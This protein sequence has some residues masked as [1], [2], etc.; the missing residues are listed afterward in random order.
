MKPHSNTFSSQQNQQN[1][2]GATGHSYTNNSRLAGSQASIKSQAGFSSGVSPNNYRQIPV[3]TIAADQ[4]LALFKAKLREQLATTATLI[5]P[6]LEEFKKRHFNQNTHAHRPNGLSNNPIRASKLQPLKSVISKKLKEPE[7]DIAKIY[8]TSYRRKI[9]PESFKNTGYRAFIDRVYSKIAT[10]FNSFKLQLNT[11]TN[12]SSQSL[13]R[14]SQQLKY[15][16]KISNSAFKPKLLTSRYVTASI[17]MFLISGTIFGIGGFLYY[18][19]NNSP[20]SAVAGV[21]EDNSKYPKLGEYTNWIQDKNGSFS[22]PQDDIDGDQLGNYEEFIIG[23][24]P[25]SANTCSPKATDSQNLFNFINPVTCKAIDLKNDSDSKKFQEIITLPEVDN[26]LTTAIVNQVEPVAAITDTNNL[27]TLFNVTSYD[28]LTAID[29][30]SLDASAPQAN[31]KKEYL[32]IIGRIDDYVKQYRSYESKDRDYPAPVNPAVYLD[33]S[34]RYQTPLKYALAIA[35]AESRFG[36]D[37]YTLDGVLT[38]P[39]QHQNIYSMGLT[40]GGKNITFKTWEDGVESFGKWYKRL[41]DKG[42]SDCIKWKI[43]N[44]NGDYCT[45]I[46]NLASSIELYLESN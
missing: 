18:Q 30:Q 41:Q 27:L 29:A 40:D 34:L 46:E 11:K 35:R 32:R 5:N 16:S 15:G 4:T 2:A 38:R 10:T 22:P 24:N 19:R 1:T 36:T 20:K 12:S 7:L 43:Y 3:R 28:Q 45:K 17:A 42:V 39:G 9:D 21:M 14:L 13:D 37:R 23:S 8:S 44:P 25:L 33:V 31:I 26:S 6:S